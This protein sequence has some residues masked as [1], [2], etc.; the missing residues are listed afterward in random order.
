M[1]EIYSTD[2]PSQSTWDNLNITNSSAF[3]AGGVFVSGGTHNINNSNISQNDS[4]EWGG[5]FYIGDVYQDTGA[6]TGPVVN[7]IDSLVEEKNS[8]RVAAALIHNEG[9]LNCTATD[10]SVSAGFLNN[11]SSYTLALSVLYLTS[12]GSLSSTLC[13][14]D[15]GSSASDNGPNDINIYNGANNTQYIMEMMRLLSV[16]TLVVHIFVSNQVPEFKYSSKYP[17]DI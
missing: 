3:I 15:G 13:D 10:T 11:T 16:M 5:G 8:G 1:G 2:T 14:L 9:S 17:S 6:P 12:G 4:V 7:L